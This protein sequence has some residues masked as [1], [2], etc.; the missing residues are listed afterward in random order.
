MML[1]AQGAI[2]YLLIISAAIIVAA[3][4]ISYLTG[5]LPII[6]DQGDKELLNSMCSKNGPL[7]TDK[8]TL[9]CGCYLK[10]NTLGELNNKNELIMAGPSTCPEA[11]PNNYQGNQ[12]VKWD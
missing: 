8:N 11:L 3:I 5:M 6:T 12:Y 2:E 9:V 10:D 7:A 4:V 1:K